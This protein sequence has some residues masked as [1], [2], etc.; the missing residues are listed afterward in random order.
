MKNER[1][2][3]GASVRVEESSGKRSAGSTP[4]AV[5]LPD[6]RER[7]GRVFSVGKEGG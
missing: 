5:P 4:S 7:V 3:L 6:W 1:E 2:K